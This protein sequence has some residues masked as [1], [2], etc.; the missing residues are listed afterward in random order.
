V[1]TASAASVPGADFRWYTTATGGTQLATG[2]AF[3]TQP[4][5]STTT[6]Y[7]EVF[8][9]TGCVSATRKAVTVGVL[10]ELATPV[11]T[12]SDSTATSITFSWSPVAGAIRYE[13]STDGSTFI[14][15]SSGV[16][17]ITHIITGLTPGQTATLQV[18]AIAENS[19][20]TSMLSAAVTGRASNPAGDL[21]FV[22]NLFSPNGDGVNDVLM[23]Y[24]NTIATLELHIFNYWG[25]EVFQS[26]D[27]RQGWDGRM[28]GKPQP[29]GVYVYTL[30]VKLQNG[31]TVKRKGNITLIR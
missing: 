26:K 9:G 11:V 16:N 31:A 10:Q 15:P 12:V 30:S 2:A 3:T 5:D 14:S 29:S 28:S 22:P 1:L 21:V 8:A 25:Q 20:Q 24:G 17:G 7:V 6:Y 23:V 13:V 27:L 19:C 4:L 18:R